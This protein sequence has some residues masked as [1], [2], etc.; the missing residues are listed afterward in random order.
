MAG[1]VSS[2]P[3]SYRFQTPI[4]DC[5]T[6]SFHGFV[7]RKYFGRSQ[8]HIIS[9]VVFFVKIGRNS[10][11]SL[12]HTRIFHPFLV[13]VFGFLSNK[14]REFGIILRQNFGTQ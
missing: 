10:T 4:V 8:L 11:G 2:H 13:S 9:P 12:A 7:Q 14:L 3:R 1:R 6:E 5:L